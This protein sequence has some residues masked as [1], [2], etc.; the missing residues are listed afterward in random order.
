MVPLV[1]GVNPSVGTMADQAGNLMGRTCEHAVKLIGSPGVL[2]TTRG[3]GVPGMSPPH[4][5]QPLGTA[6]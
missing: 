3:N 6:P 2:R 1:T 4:R 5:Q